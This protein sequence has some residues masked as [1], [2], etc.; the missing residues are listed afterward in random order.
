MVTLLPGT[1]TDST[2][3]RVCVWGRKHPYLQEKPMP[4]GA[5]RM[6][7]SHTN[8]FHLPSGLIPLRLA[9][10]P[11]N[12]ME[13]PPFERLPRGRLATSVMHSLPFSS[14]I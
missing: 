12:H 8:P 1:G 13:S 4:T 3:Y 9:P 2:P 10:K 5:P 11:L 6:Q 7:G 14:H